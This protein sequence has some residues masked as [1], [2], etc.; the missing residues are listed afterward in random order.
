MAQEYWILAPETLDEDYSP[1]WEVTKFINKFDKKIERL[2]RKLSKRLSAGATPEKRERRKAL[3]VHHIGLRKL[4][5]RGV[6]GDQQDAAEFLRWIIDN[7]T[8]EKVGQN[9]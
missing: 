4:N 6:V 2:E 5:F 3:E 1:L 9:P 7:L 8:H